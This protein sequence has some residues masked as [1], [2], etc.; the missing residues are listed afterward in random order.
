MSL[1]CVN[2]KITIA[3]QKGRR[4][5]R[6]ATN[7]IRR[8]LVR[9]SWRVSARGSPL[10]AGCWLL[11]S[12]E[13]RCF[14]CE[15][16]ST[17]ERANVA[18]AL[19]VINEMMCHLVVASCSDVKIA[20]PSQRAIGADESALIDTVRAVQLDDRSMAFL[21]AAKFFEGPVAMTHLRIVKAL[22]DI[23]SVAGLSLSGVNSFRV[24]SGN[25]LRERH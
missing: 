24:V 8:A 5:E 15:M 18:G 21:F 12:A 16:R 23:F 6:V 20:H 10:A 2:V 19:Q 25:D 4:H 22:T 14:G 13:E 7:Q 3:N 17:F 9:G 11:A 1:I